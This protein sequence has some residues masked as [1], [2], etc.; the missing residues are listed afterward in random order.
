VAVA[1]AASIGSSGTA[2][3]SSGS[4]RS[5]WGGCGSSG[6]TVVTVEN[7]QI[8]M[9]ELKIFSMCVQD[10]DASK[11]TNIEIYFFL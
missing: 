9:Y 11:T 7:L 3:S 8:G 10:N 6:S 5:C 1:I 4:C 2:V